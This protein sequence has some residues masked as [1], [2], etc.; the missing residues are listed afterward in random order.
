MSTTDI[1]ARLFLPQPTMLMCAFSIYSDFGCYDIL[2]CLFLH[3]MLLNS[4]LQYNNLI[5]H[6]LFGK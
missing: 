5:Y 6:F 4:Q 2:S 1:E 3:L